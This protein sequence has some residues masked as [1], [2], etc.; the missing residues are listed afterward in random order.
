[1]SR[2]QTSGHPDQPTFGAE[3]AAGTPIPAALANAMFDATRVLASNWA[4]ACLAQG[5]TNP[6]LRRTLS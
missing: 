3:E 1:M 4:V 6:S 5:S 2:I